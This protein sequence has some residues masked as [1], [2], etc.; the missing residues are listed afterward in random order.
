MFA[1]RRGINWK[2]LKLKLSDFP[3]KH[4]LM[5]LDCCYA[6]LACNDVSRCGNEL[7]SRCGEIKWASQC[8]RHKAFDI[9][10]A[11]SEREKTFEDI[12][13]FTQ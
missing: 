8:L 6:G 7:Q 13:T 10:T 11:T 1:G 3:G 5:I 9:L 4:K 12:T 2:E